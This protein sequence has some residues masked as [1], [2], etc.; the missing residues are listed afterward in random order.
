MVRT[1]PQWFAILDLIAAGR[2][3]ELR[4]DTR[5]IS[6]FRRDPND[7]RSHVEWGGGALL[8]IGC[9]PITISRWLFG[10]EP[11]EAV[12]QIERDPDFG[13]DRLASALLRFPRGQAMFA[14]AGQLV[15][16]QRMHIFGTTG[17]IEVEIPF[18]APSDRPTRIWVDGRTTTSAAP[19]R[20]RSRLRRWISTGSR[21]SDSS[22][23]FA[24]WA[25]CPEVWKTPSPTW[26]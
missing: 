4:L 24:A 1:H 26:R 20:S 6:Y 8:D 23:R 21:R 12:G 17:R 10:D 3:G 7:V 5:H 9:Y 22:T 25:T 19:A 15:P 14:C 11:V 13:V 2:I 16:Y 18:N